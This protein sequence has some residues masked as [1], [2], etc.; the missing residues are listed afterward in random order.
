[1]IIVHKRS[2][3]TLTTLLTSLK[4]VD[5]IKWP[6][7]IITY[8]LCNHMIALH[9]VFDR[10]MKFLIET[11]CYYINH[12]LACMRIAARTSLGDKDWRWFIDSIF[13][14]NFSPKLF[15]WLQNDFLSKSFFCPQKRD[16]VARLLFKVLQFFFYFLS[17]LY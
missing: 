15:G 10:T 12:Y 2:L 11:K 4:L 13:S 17:Y 8:K 14:F 3:K 7:W 9:G 1:V 5:I 16:L 6:L